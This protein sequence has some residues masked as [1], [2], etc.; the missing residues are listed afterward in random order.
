MHFNFFNYL[1]LGYFFSVSALIPC[2]LKLI[3]YWKIGLP[4]PLGAHIYEK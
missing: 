4:F 3:L 1:F 2:F